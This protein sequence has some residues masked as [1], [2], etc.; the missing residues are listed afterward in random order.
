MLVKY[1]DMLVKYHYLLVKYQ[2]LLVKY[3]DKYMYILEL[4]VGVVVQELFGSEGIDM[5]VKY[6]RM[7][8]ALLSSGLGHYCLLM[9]AISC[10]W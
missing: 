7:D 5:L 1:Q 9:A 3:Q 2:Y 8:T 4:C 10:T 6:L